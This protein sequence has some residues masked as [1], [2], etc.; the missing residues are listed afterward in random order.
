[1]PVFAP[2]SF[3]TSKYSVAEVV[4]VGIAREAAAAIFLTLLNNMLHGGH[5]SAV[6]I[7]YICTAWLH[8][9]SLIKPKV[10]QNFCECFELNTE[11]VSVVCLIAGRRMRRYALHFFVM[12]DVQSV[13]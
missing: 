7:G 11:A 8:E 9:S 5:S 4:V 12:F 6:S 3:S 2:I 10:L 1:M 13:D